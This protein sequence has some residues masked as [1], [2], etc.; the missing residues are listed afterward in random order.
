V[1]G[2][3][4]SD[5]RVDMGGLRGGDGSVSVSTGPRK[6]VPGHRVP[7]VPFRSLLARGRTEIQLVCF[8]LVNTIFFTL[9]NRPKKQRFGLAVP[10]VTGSLLAEFVNNKTAREAS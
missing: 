5:A 8:T 2:A 3:D 10:V 6:Y 7:R 1:A 4:G 9:R